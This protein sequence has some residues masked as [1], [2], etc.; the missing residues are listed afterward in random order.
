MKF[1]IDRCAGRLLADAVKKIC[2]FGQSR[3]LMFFILLRYPPGKQSGR[4]G[5]FRH[6][7]PLCSSGGE[8][9]EFTKHRQFS[10]EKH[11]RCLLL[12]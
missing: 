4:E 1:L 9:E 7:Q 12:N 6:P 5:R 11:P 10:L 3:K 8:G 2:E